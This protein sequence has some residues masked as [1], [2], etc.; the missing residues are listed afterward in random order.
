MRASN[1]D[2]CN[3]QAE[4]NKINKEKTLLLKTVQDWRAIYDRAE[5]AKILL[6]MTVEAADE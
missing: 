6:E 2:I 4:L 5:D 3:K 1:P